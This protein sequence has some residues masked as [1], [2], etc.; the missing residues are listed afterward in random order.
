VDKVAVT[1]RLWGAFV[2]IIAELWMNIDCGRVLRENP[3]LSVGTD[4]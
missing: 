4:W 3:G 2:S 1:R